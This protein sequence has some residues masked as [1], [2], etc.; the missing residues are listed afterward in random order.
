MGR[1]QDNS[2]YKARHGCRFQPA[3]GSVRNL[4]REG[5]ALRQSRNFKFRHKE[6]AS[7]PIAWAEQ[8]RPVVPLDDKKPLP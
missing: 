4:L 1:L 2:K 6:Q 7:F 8:G 3:R 5:F